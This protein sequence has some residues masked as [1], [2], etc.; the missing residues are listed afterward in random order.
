MKGLQWHICDLCYTSLEIDE[1]IVTA[2]KRLF[3]HIAS[4]THCLHH[5]LPPQRNVRTASSLR[6]RGHYT[7]PHTDFNLYK[8]SFINRCLF[9]FYLSHLPNPSPLVIRSF[10]LVHQYCMLCLLFFVHTLL[11]TLYWYWWHFIILYIEHVLY[12]T[13]CALVTVN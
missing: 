1:L 8:N 2:D 3:D 13:I 5:L 4:T 10:V 7:L 11:M 12:C 6:T 9:E